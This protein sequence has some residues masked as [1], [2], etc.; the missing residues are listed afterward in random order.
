MIDANIQLI[1]PYGYNTFALRNASARALKSI[2]LLSWK[3]IHLQS[4]FSLR[5]QQF[6][7]IRSTAGDGLNGQRRVHSADGGK[8]GTIAN[9]QIWNIPG[10]AVCVDD[11]GLG[12]AAHAR[13][14]RTRRKQVGALPIPTMIFPSTGGTRAM[15][16]TPHS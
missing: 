8:Y 13:G 7:P 4:K 6:D 16:S 9:P 14:T 10:T 5:R 3:L 2:G 15:R 1:P 11:T 12:I